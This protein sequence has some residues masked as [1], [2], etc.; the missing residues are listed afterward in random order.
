MSAKARR[1]EYVQKLEKTVLLLLSEKQQ[2]QA[3]VDLLI[4]K[5]E[6]NKKKIEHLENVLIK[7]YAQ[8]TKT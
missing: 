4:V 3:Q 5:T 2:L 6:E 1:K 8:P 7:H